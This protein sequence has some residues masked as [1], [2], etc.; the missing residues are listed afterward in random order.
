MRKFN[1][2][3]STVKID[4]AR[5]GV[6]QI[7]RTR[8]RKVERKQIARSIRVR[9]IGKTEDGVTVAQIR[10]RTRH[11]NSICECFPCSNLLPENRST[12]KNRLA[13]LGYEWPDDVALT[14]A[15]FE[16]LA[17]SQPK[18]RFRLVRAPGWYGSVFAIPGQA[19]EAG[20]AN[21]EVY[22]DPKS[23]AH[24]GAF[25][26]GEGS[27][28][29]WQKRVAKP[30]RKSS[31][32]QLAITA[33]FAAP[34]LRQLGMDSFGIN[35]FS[36]T[37]DGKTLCLTVAASVAG[38]VGDDGLPC[39][40]DSEAGIEAIARGHRDNVAPLDETADGEHK[41]ALETKARMV[42]FL[43][44]RSRPR[45]L[46][47]IYERHHNLSKK[48]LPNHPSEFQRARFARCCP[49]CPYAA[50]RR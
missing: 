39:W 48:R 27:L 28:E 10:F 25:A 36:E 37:S 29:D 30:S 40:A 16:A 49:R 20:R 45:K 26:L 12:I 3:Q 8:E 22:V 46:S 11:G 14:K 18:R 21:T 5:N 19:F 41:M 9:A 4:L 43:V 32:L 50:P 35:W 31:R 13:D 6:F 47:P 33:A 2:I 44:A 42:A 7:V 38:L 34:F 24:V 17:K 1:T 23:D 15:L